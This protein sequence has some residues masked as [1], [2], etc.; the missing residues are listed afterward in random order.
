MPDSISGSANTVQPSRA[1]VNDDDMSD[2]EWEVFLGRK[3]KEQEDA[4]RENY[5]QHEADRRER[6]IL[7][8]RN[9]PVHHPVKSV[10]EI[11]L[12]LLSPDY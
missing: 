4:Y 1:D 10:S 11:S 12:C 7:Q 8:K 5:A 6:E 9:D 3:K 2:G